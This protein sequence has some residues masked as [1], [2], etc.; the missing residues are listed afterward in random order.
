MIEINN[1]L[2]DSLY[3]KEKNYNDLVSY[4]KEKYKEKKDNSSS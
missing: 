4:N 2:H 1:K 3:L